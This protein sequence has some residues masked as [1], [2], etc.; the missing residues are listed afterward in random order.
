MLETDVRFI[1]GDNVILVCHDDNYLRLT[2]VDK[3]VE[4]TP[5]S[6]IPVFK[7]EM[8]LNFSKS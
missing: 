2:G 3:K 6:D 8:P 1:E 7:N 5:L 4:N